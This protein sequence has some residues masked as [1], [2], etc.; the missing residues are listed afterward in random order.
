VVRKDPNYVEP[1]REPDRIGPHKVVE[2]TPLEG[3]LKE[4]YIDGF[5]IT[6]D[7]AVRP[8]GRG[9]GT[10][11]APSPLAYFTIGIGF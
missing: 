5:T 1:P 8:E 10:G 6:C 7:E 3:Q 9:G 11:T 4:G 2:V